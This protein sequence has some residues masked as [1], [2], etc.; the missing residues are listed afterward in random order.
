MRSKKNLVIG[1]LLLLLGIGLSEHSLLLSIFAGVAGI[2]MM[3]LYAASKLKRN[4]SETS[5]VSS[6]TS[7]I[8]PAAKTQQA[9]TQ[10]VSFSLEAQQLYQQLAD[11]YTRIVNNGCFGSLAQIEEKMDRC[12]C[13]REQW[14]EALCNKDFVTLL[15]NKAKYDEYL[16]GFR[17]PQFGTWR[18]IQAEGGDDSIPDGLTK[19]LVERIQGKQKMLQEFWEAQ[20]WYEGLIPS[21]Q[22]YELTVDPD[23]EPL[24]K[25][26]DYEYPNTNNVTSRTPLAKFN[27]FYAIDLETTGLSEV[28]NEIIQIAIIKFHHFQ[29]VEI[30]SSYV[31]PRKGLKL[32]AAAINHITED[33]VADAPYIEQIMQSVDAFIGEK[34][35]I[36]AHNL[37]FEYKF[38]AANGS[39][40]IAKKR[41]LYDTLELSKRI[42]RLESYSLEN[43]CRN[44]FKFTPALHNAESDAL[45][46]GLLFR[47]I[48]SERIGSLKDALACE[49]GEMPC[50]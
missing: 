41:P 42:W 13:F 34:A 2:V 28:K 7:E 26:L 46:C 11:Q 36:I 47:E 19:A 15:Q 40:N 4:T 48:C 16:K 50:M 38:L 33:M 20:K 3:I 31:K 9:N 29:P 12:K 23:A 37:Q 35:P 5:A 6:K 14:M 45:T 44:T 49:L 27:D 1:F 21:L 8:Q 18:T 24:S 22:T 17:L 32:E 25:K 30:L 39:E 10:S 43:V